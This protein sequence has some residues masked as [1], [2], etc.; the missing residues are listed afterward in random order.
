[1]TVCLEVVSPR[2][3]PAHVCVDRH[4]PRRARQGLVFAVWDVFVGVRVD[5]LLGEPKVC[6]REAPLS[7]RHDIPTIN[8]MERVHY[9][10]AAQRYTTTREGIHNFFPKSNRHPITQL[11]KPC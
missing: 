5:V 11:N 4:V 8:V 3:L 10:N 2:L 1:M 7:M 9:L 6:V